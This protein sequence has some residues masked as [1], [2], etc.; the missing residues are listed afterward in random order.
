MA[1]KDAAGQQHEIDGLSFA[2][3]IRAHQGWKK[4]LAEAL[5]A[6]PVVDSDI[7]I[8]RRDDCCELGR[9][10]RS[11]ASMSQRSRAVFRELF[12]THAALHQSAA[13]VLK[14]KQ[15]GQHQAAREMLERGLF[16]R[17]SVYVQGLL[18]Q[19]F[20]VGD[21]S[22]YYSRAGHQ[23]GTGSQSTQ[24][25]AAGLASRPVAP[26]RTVQ[27]VDIPLEVAVAGARVVPSA[28]LAAAP[29]VHGLRPRALAAARI[30]PVLLTEDMAVQALAA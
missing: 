8:I 23:G 4:R 25:S 16:A 10:M 19:L 26:R 6:G 15:S 29:S 21:R 11:E 18:A 28:R 7:A 2:G 17:N 22:G 13:E 14:L 30:A 27:Q 3:A 20:A 9:W 12:G 24:G 1:S 5:D